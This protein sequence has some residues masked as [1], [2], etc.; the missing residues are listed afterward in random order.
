M[1]REICDKLYARHGGRSTASLMEAMVDAFTIFSL[2]DR[3]GQMDHGAAA[4]KCR[5]SIVH[6][7]SHRAAPHRIATRSHDVVNSA[8]D[9]Y[10][11]DVGCE[12]AKTPSAKSTP[13]DDSC[14]S[15]M[16]LQ[17]FPPRTVRTSN[18]A[19]R[20]QDLRETPISLNASPC[21]EIISWLRGTLVV[22]PRATHGRTV[23][24]SPSKTLAMQTDVFLLLLRGFVFLLC[25][26]VSLSSG[27]YFST[28]QRGK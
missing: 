5:N 12:R 19:S 20:K 15:R 13:G 25:R 28:H 4:T 8:N 7:Q 17:T 11:P 27:Q 6:A 16:F 3:F 21:F 1:P 2:S 10:K 23:T 9:K 26:G 18:S 24:S 14:R 22:L